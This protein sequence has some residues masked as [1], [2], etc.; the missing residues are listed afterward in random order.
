MLYLMMLFGIV[1]AVWV[2][3]DSKR[4]GMFGATR[5]V[6]ATGIVFP[7]GLAAYL[8]RRPLRGDERRSGGTGWNTA[9]YFGLIW[10]LLCVSIS[11]LFMLLMLVIQSLS[12]TPVS[13]GIVGASFAMNVF[14][15][16]AVWVV[17][18]VLTLLLGAFL[19]QPGL[20]EVASSTEV[21]RT[22]DV[23]T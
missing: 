6:I 8:A 23:T 20:V 22:E 9:R 3:H 2:H 15:T 1:L 13:L 16:V 21:I 11:M 5:W 7:I 10:S 18:A 17:P 19:R 14:L 12:E 4:R